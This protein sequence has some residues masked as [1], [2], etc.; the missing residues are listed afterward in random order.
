MSRSPG[1]Q[2]NFYDQTTADFKRP[3]GGG[4]GM[5]SSGMG[6]DTDAPP[7][8]DM[9]MPPPLNDLSQLINRAAEHEEEHNRKKNVANSLFQQQVSTL[10]VTSDVLPDLDKIMADCLK[11]AEEEV[12]QDTRESM[13]A[14]RASR[15]R[16][17]DAAR[18]FADS[19][20]RLDGMVY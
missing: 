2:N 18:D 8:R 1:I 4:G 11:Q 20:A 12:G 16:L 6:M 19:I 7:R 17:V 10:D 13:E 5:P 15:S 3:H 9:N 14:M